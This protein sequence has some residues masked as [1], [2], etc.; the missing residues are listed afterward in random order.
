MLRSTHNLAATLS[1]QN[2]HD[3]A[4]IIQRECYTGLGK[5]QG[6]MHPTT[7][8]TANNLANTLANLGEYSE[9]EVIYRETLVRTRH[10]LG[11]EHDVTKTTGHYL[12][13]L[14]D[15][16]HTAIQTLP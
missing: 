3:E 8:A 6:T 11:A 9:C 16:G 2:K 10:V 15:S 1:N 5:V 4:L 14:I 13:R 7:L 12:Q